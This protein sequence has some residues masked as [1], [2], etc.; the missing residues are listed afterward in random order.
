MV[1]RA[2]E[3]FLSIA[4]QQDLLAKRD[5]KSVLGQL[6]DLDG[7]GTP[8]KARHLCLE[9]GLLSNKLA[10][11]I[12]RSVMEQLTAESR[13]VSASQRQELGDYSISKQVGAGP[14]GIVYRARSRKGGKVALTLLNPQLSQDKEKLKRVLNGARA[15][16]KVAHGALISV[17]DSGEIN[18]QAFVVQEYLPGETL[19]ARIDAGKTLT[20]TEAIRLAF[21]LVE[22]LQVAERANVMHGDIRPE[23][24]IYD[25][26]GARLGELGLTPPGYA[27]R[28]YKEAAYKAPEI[29]AGEAGDPRSDFWSLGATLY[30]AVTGRP[31]FKDLESVR[32]DEATPLHETCPDVSYGFSQLIELMLK[33]K[34]G[35]RYQ[36]YQAL[37][38]DV[39]QVLSGFSPQLHKGEFMGWA[40]SKPKGGKLGAASRGKLAAPRGDRGSERSPRRRRGG[41]EDADSVPVLPI[42]AIGAALLVLLAVFLLG[43]GKSSDTDGG[44]TGKRDKGKTKK[45]GGEASGQNEA[46]LAIAEAARNALKDARA[47]TKGW[48]LVERCDFIVQNFPNTPAANKAEEL[49]GDTR[50]KLV[51]D[52]R[53]GFDQERERI[54]AMRQT[55]QLARAASSFQKLIDRLRADELKQEAGRELESLEK[56]INA[57]LSKLNMRASELARQDN[58]A[59]AAKTLEESL[60]LRDDAGRKKALAQIDSYRGKASLIAG[61][62][63]AKESE[64]HRRMVDR[65]EGQVKRLASSANWKGITDKGR[66]L[67]KKITVR[68]LRPRVEIHVRAAQDLLT[69]ADLV[70]AAALDLIGQPFELELA[71]GRRVKGEIKD[72]ED[73]G[74]IVVQIPRGE[75]TISRSDL[76]LTA[77][78]DLLVKVNGREP[79]IPMLLGLLQIYRGQ[80]GPGLSD[81]ERAQKKGSTAAK[82]YLDNRKVFEKV[83]GKAGA[84]IAGKPEAKAV[85]KPKRRPKKPKLRGGPKEGAEL[86]G[87]DV[88]PIKLNKLIYDNLRK[89]FPTNT[90]IGYGEGRVQA[91]FSFFNGT[92][93]PSP[94]A[95]ILRGMRPRADARRQAAVLAKSGSMFHQMVANTEFLIKVRFSYSSSLVRNTRFFLVIED[96]KKPELFRSLFGQQ[97]FYLRRKKRT[98]RQ[99]LPAI[100]PALIRTGAGAQ[101][102]IELGYKNGEVW[103][104]LNG[105]QY[106]SFKGVGISKGRVG[107]VWER[108]SINLHT[109]RVEGYPEANWVLKSLGKDA[110]EVR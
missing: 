33:K 105:E 31:P 88:D 107:I 17:L 40:Q 49:R 72:V 60:P 90:D 22:G 9:R 71:K 106:A 69:L 14:L 92:K 83:F 95:W 85:V 41:D 20:E 38:A 80:V 55:G 29:I 77:M 48:D 109:V 39:E 12:K 78:E 64:G 32:F 47:T 3:L 56:L 62:K 81:L 101:H 23:S 104:S 46:K 24:I 70:S 18:G 7:Q 103:C 15:A 36:S 76:S 8:R 89:L 11:K 84:V 6:Q 27:N 34:P 86:V 5:A 43:G 63:H 25:D 51:Q 74:S 50:K 19:R 65:F 91:L 66:P 54:G 102:E 73:D 97:L 87:S 21:Q 108:M 57:Q 30:H 42:V 67:L 110:D 79:K 94:K 68:S 1:R 93:V 99:G 10:K 2:D 44:K 75:V 35:D 96:L 37:L 98:V 16:E 58:F 13:A 52:E 45:N 82:R 28:S 4:V 100:N 53:V 59:Q 26:G 61:A